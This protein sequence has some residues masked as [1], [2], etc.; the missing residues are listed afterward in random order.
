[1]RVNLVGAPPQVSA[2][3]RE[4]ALEIETML[5]NKVRE[6][7]RVIAQLRN[8]GRVAARFLRLAIHLLK[9]LVER[10]RAV[11]DVGGF[12]PRLLKNCASLR[13]MRCRKPF[14]V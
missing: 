11:E 1:M 2:G 13:E 4:R 8:L 3:L 10:Q 6:V 9:D 7:R 12:G 14:R 5:V